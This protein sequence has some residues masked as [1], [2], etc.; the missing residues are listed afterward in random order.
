MLA[1]TNIKVFFLVKVAFGVILYSIFVMMAYQLWIIE[2]MSDTAINGL[3]A[4]DPQYYHRLAIDMREKTISEGWGV[5]R[6][7]PAG[8]GPAG[9]LSI[10]YTLV[11]PYPW[12]VVFVN[13]LCHSLAS[14]FL[15][16]ILNRVV[17]MRHALIAS[18]YF[19]ISPFEMHWLSQ[20]NKES[21]VILGV[22]VFV[23]GVV[24]LCERKNYGL[25]WIFI[26]CAI[27]SINRPYVVQLLFSAS[28]LLALFFVR[29]KL[30]Q[31]RKGGR[32]AF[33]NEGL[34]AFKLV[35][36]S[37]LLFPLMTGAASNHKNQIKKDLT[38]SASGLPLFIDSRLYAVSRARMSFRQ[39][40]SSPNKTVRE[41]NLIDEAEFHDVVDMIYY[42]PRALQI[43]LLA[44]FPNHWPI[45]SR[46]N[47]GSTFRLMVSVE[48]FIAYFFF[49][50]LVF[51]L[52]KHNHMKF[53]VP[54]FIMLFV[55]QIYGL[56]TPLIG[57]LRR[58]I[59]ILYIA[60]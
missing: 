46:I 35:I 17:S 57:T 50:F 42:A 56:A 33:K 7:R 51:G 3:L 45:F 34:L 26:G 13:S 14:I 54:V 59:S 4:G 1:D 40:L 8:Q 58:Y 32:L 28:I 10:L 16:L 52:Y 19:I 9:F 22:F 47:D 11:G 20:I 23:F 41:L 53:L 31:I 24:L 36:I 25:Y 48:M 15:I 49:I 5:W 12:L 27:I 30:G 29:A 21:F 55:L 37:V 6:L 38:W 2:Y 18:L 60:S 39:H 44:P 43:A